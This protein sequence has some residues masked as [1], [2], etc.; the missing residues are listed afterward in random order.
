LYAASG[1]FVIE[2]GTAGVRL[3]FGEIQTPALQPGLHYRLPWPFESHRVIETDRLQRID[4]GFNAK[5]VQE[6]VNARIRS[7]GYMAGGN[8]VP[9]ETVKSAT[10]FQKSPAPE[11]P[12]LLT[13]D[14]N[15]INLRWA[16]Q[17]RV[18]DPVAYA[19]NVAEPE[20]VV[21]SMALAALRSVI[22]RA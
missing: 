9:S 10:W 19:F 16:M 21:R 20:D 7:Q 3:R 15:L 18:K 11:E 8:L 12:F 5:P 14:G 22:A 4:Y 2:P 1:L 17:Y 6:L 13:G